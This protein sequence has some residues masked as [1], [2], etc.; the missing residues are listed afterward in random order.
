MPVIPQHSSSRLEAGLSDS[1]RPFAE[2]F[3]RSGSKHGV[4]PALLGAIAMHETGRGT[5]RAFLES[6]NAMG[7]SDDNGPISFAD[8]GGVDASIDHMAERIGKSSIYAPAR[9]AG[10]IDALA[11]IY[12]PVGAGNDPRGFNKDWASG[13]TNFYSQLSDAQ[14]TVQERQGVATNLNAMKGVAPDQAAQVD[15][16][17]RKYQVPFQLALDKKDDFQNDADAVSISD[18]IHKKDGDGNVVH[19]VTASWLS[20][21]VNLA[22]AKDDVAG[23]QNLETSIRQHAQTVGVS[24]NFDPVA[25]G[26]AVEA[27]PHANANRIAETRSGFFQ[28]LTGGVSDTAKARDFGLFLAG[29]PTDD[30]AIIERAMQSRDQGRTVVQ[31]GVRQFLGS[32]IGGAV[33]PIGVGL[34]GSLGT[35]A[36]GLTLAGGDM[37]AVGSGSA[38]QRVFNEQLDQGVAPEQAHAQAMK[39]AGFGAFVSAALAAT[40]PGS[41]KLALSLS[42]MRQGV[43]ATVGQVLKFIA[44]DAGLQGAAGGAAN[45]ATNVYEGRPALEGTG[46]SVAGQALFSI[47]HLPMLI[48][49]AR[50]GSLPT[51]FNAAS[52]S[53]QT[54]QKAQD[55]L[56]S[57]D[58]L[59]AA[60]DASK[61]A[62]RDPQAFAD[63]AQKHLDVNQLESS[64][65]IPAN[66]IASVFFQDAVT[67]EQRQFANEQLGQ[68]ANDVGIDPQVL[69]EAL[70]TGGSVEVQKAPLV[71]KYGA[72]PI[73]EA[74][75][76]SLTTGVEVEKER[77]QTSVKDMQAE[78]GRL[79]QDADVPIQ[80]KAIRSKLVT[81]Q[82]AGGVGMA[83]QDADHSLAVLM[84]GLRTFATKRG[85]TLTDALQ[86]I[87]LSLEVNTDPEALKKAA[88]AG[89]S[90]DVVIPDIPTDQAVPISGEQS[91]AKKSFPPPV[92]Y[93]ATFTPEK[94]TALN[95]A[96]ESEK[97][98]RRDAVKEL[99]TKEAWRRVE[100]G[101]VSETVVSVIA[102][103]ETSLTRNQAV[104]R[105]VKGLSLSK[106]AALEVVNRAAPD[107]A[108][109]NFQV[110]IGDVLNEATSWLQEHNQVKGDESLDEREMA[111]LHMES[112]AQEAKDIEQEIKRTQ[113]GFWEAVKKSGGLASISSL[114]NKMRVGGADPLAG[115]MKDTLENGSVPPGVL[116][117]KA[118]GLDELRGNLGGYGYKFDT[119][120]EMIQAI[121]AKLSNGT[122]PQWSGYGGDELFFQSG[123]DESLVAAHNLSTENLQHAF[124]MGGLAVPSL[125]I[126]DANKSTFSNFGEITLLGAP[127]II[128]PRGDKST[129]VFN[130][131]AYSPR[132]PNVS[133]ELTKQDVASLRNALGEV[134]AGVLEGKG[135]SR[136][137]ET[138]G[139]LAEAIKDNGVRKG[140]ENS[141]LVWAEFV[142]STGK[143]DEKT[144]K[145]KDYEFESAIR[146]LSRDGEESGFQKW[147]DDLEK[148]LALN[149]TERIFNGFTNSGNRRYLPHDLDTVVKLM[150]KGLRDGEG[151]NYGVPSVRASYAKQFRTLEQIQKSRDSIVTSE[152][153]K[154]LKEEADAEF[155]KLADEALPFRTGGKNSGFG[156]LDAFSDDLKAMA[157]GGSENF[158]HLREM[159]PDG[160]PFEKMRGFLEKLRG[161]PTEYFEAKLQ[162]AV[163]VNE[164]DSAVV[165]KGTPADV[166]RELEKRGLEVFQYDKAKPG[167]REAVMKEAA[168]SRN[169]LFQGERGAVNFADGRTVVHLFQ[170]ADFSTF[171]HES[172]HVFIREMR[173]LVEAGFGDAQMIRDYRTLLDF[174][175]WKEGKLTREHEE[176]VA[177]AF[178]AYLMEG[179]APSV[180]L[181]D[182]FRR[183]KS[184]LLEIYKTVRG[185][186]VQ[187]ND[188]I[189]GVFDRM[190][191]SEKEIADAREYY[192]LSKDLVEMITKDEQKRA[193]FLQNKEAIQAREIERKVKVAMQA[194]FKAIGGRDGVEKEVAAQVD[195]EPFYSLL[196]YAKGDKISLPVMRKVVGTQWAESLA[197]KFPRVFSDTGTLTHEG[198]AA[199]FG[200]SS[201]E[202]LLEAFNKALPRDEAIKARANEIV[203]AREAEL[204]TTIKGETVTG[205]DREVHG[206]ES[207]AYLIAETQL[208]SDEV[209]RQRSA[210][211]ARFTEK[212]YRDA[213]RDVILNKPVG[214]ATRYD[215]FAKAER[216]FAK[217]VV[218]LLQQDKKMEALEARR[219]QLLNHALV[220]ESIKARDE[221]YRIEARYTPNKMKSALKGV[222][223]EFVTPIVAVLKRYGLLADAGFANLL[224]DHAADYD[225]NQIPALDDTGGLGALMPTW[226]QDVPPGDYRHL[227]TLDQFQQIDDFAQALMSFGRDEMRSLENSQ[228]DTV[229]KFVA[230]SAD[231]M[232]GRKDKAVAQQDANWIKKMWGKGFDWIINNTFQM[233]FL[234]DANDGFSFRTGGK[235]GPLGELYQKVFDSEIAKIKTIGKMRTTLDPHLKALAEDAAR[236]R[237]EHG[238]FF[239]VPEL[240]GNYLVQEM[241]KAGKGKWSSDKLV[242]ILLNVGN[243]WN[244]EVLARSYGFRDAEIQSVAKFFSKDGLKAIQGVWDSV[245]EF[246]PKLD[247]T[248]FK[249]YNRHLEKVEATPITL[250]SR[251]GDSVKLDGGYYPLKFDSEIN[252]RAGGFKE[253]DDINQIAKRVYRQTR[254]SD[255]M[256]K[257]RVK[258]HSLPPKLDL[259]V[260]FNHINETSHLIHYGEVARDWH[261]VSMN[262]HWKKV[263]TDKN[264][265]DSWKQVRD[266]L[267]YQANPKPKQAAT[268]AG[269]ALDNLIESQ[270]RLAT[271][272]MLGFKVKSYVANISDFFH[273]SQELGG[274]KWIARGFK[275]A[276]LDSAGTTVVGLENSAA[277]NFIKARSDYM[278][279]RENFIE[280]ELREGIDTVGPQKG[281]KVKVGQ[282]EFGVADL[283]DMAIHLMVMRDKA[284]TT[285]VWLGAFHK[286]LETVADR[287]AP[288]STQ[289]KEAVRFADRTIQN[290][291]PSS[292]KAEL[293]ALQRE[294][295]AWRALTMFGSW[296]AK[297]GSRLTNE[298]MAWH[299]GKISNKD[300][301]RHIAYEVV[302]QGWFRLTVM[303]LLAASMPGWT[304]FL[305]QPFK[306]MM[307][308]IPLVKDVPNFWTHKGVDVGAGIRRSL[309]VFEGADRAA[310]LINDSLSVYE[311]NKGSDVLAWDLGRFGE[312]FLGVPAL[313]PVKDMMRAADNATGEEN[314]KEYH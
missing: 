167:D 266:W 64:V 49:A 282:R 194:Y 250:V 16:L 55:N 281:W 111:R 116:S 161:L 233:P 192:G 179:K 113:I 115:D 283:R 54:I 214:L 307:S 127:S 50:H 99:A 211:S 309:P 157:Q 187:L 107:T 139:G 289:E 63:L 56:A 37:V 200:F 25:E 306:E 174:A 207:L 131:D 259:S 156:A 237:D 91:P 201:P 8:R 60:A 97:Q 301:M 285:V 20:D 96:R 48:D 247:E 222:E 256:T 45:A 176:K 23:L 126:I 304:D 42:G 269:R 47:L 253:E 86:R 100:K 271:V 120:D 89:Q 34:V 153:M 210:Q 280:R 29:N 105:L 296:M 73:F 22:K 231:R 46:E 108:D 155:T 195:K 112:L 43:P 265:N 227:L 33:E 95:K 70:K 273:A 204:R 118:P 84:A 148:K 254:P 147:L 18:A 40:L 215:L 258:G 186:N 272:A 235:L 57:L 288:L 217:E 297:F 276:G 236:I 35:P 313:N 216:R 123:K 67:P 144:L 30:Q 152:Q 262:D 302:G 245:N 241:Q 132:Y 4:D 101:D 251:D 62:Q 75:K 263:F 238:E 299:E 209:A 140:L 6:Q 104:N 39:A 305:T 229:T 27:F 294:R 287:N 19:P 312:Y 52:D 76:K 109:E 85:E 162:R 300:Y 286:Y 142:K 94:V 166:I 221:R 183:F 154:A 279:N 93:K 3:R 68:F 196:D 92:E 175:G 246:Y 151:F 303:G 223:N 141:P 165:P 129:K 198:L 295:G 261:R 122:D 219:K 226:M 159:Y 74:V 228:W 44:A 193:E 61:T 145:L 275:E 134:Y 135:G 270:K 267:E 128:D 98:K 189:R 71:S 178:E 26:M 158:R 13:V 90:K 72:H 278:V 53:M 59:K 205:A 160:E 103:S 177:R 137:S 149:P 146:K 218:R 66:E 15:S 274:F 232:N 17:S 310:R 170:H 298:G 190:L 150:K 249:L 79:A 78:L 239:D 58:T 106:D 121:S 291:Q 257:S 51:S 172:S 185:L 308:W 230:A 290:T 243:Q 82:D 138:I 225:L 182:A 136:Y 208:L 7:V 163:G 264:G 88:V 41:S 102:G 125:G 220:L 119:V 69:N 234:T 130:A 268:S 28:N 277:R 191:A 24:Q 213:A 292:L 124:K 32:T 77:L 248:H 171:L 83:P 197:K 168:T 240:A 114:K 9:E 244:K 133:I 181:A 117:N 206:G 36:T 2:T 10:T 199:Q 38:Y 11:K 293:N 242:S 260:L 284:S 5:S 311:G 87:G 252:A 202:A 212:A 164:F 21:P 81:P 65:T 143:L 188:N 314:F 1:L 224:K 12:A 31:P 173:T 169:L 184:W 80:I 255:G 203:H 110:A 180:G 14:Q